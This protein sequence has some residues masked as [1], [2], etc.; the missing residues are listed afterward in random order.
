MAVGS[1]SF[2]NQF[3]VVFT[4]LMWRTVQAVYLD[5]QLSGTIITDNLFENCMTGILLGGGRDNLVMF[6]HFTGNDLAVHLDNRGMNWQQSVRSTRLT[7][8]RACASHARVCATC[9][10]VA[11][12]QQQHR[13]TGS[14]AFFRQLHPTSVRHVIPSVF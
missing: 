2:Q 14:A 10:S 3:W 9:N 1:G 11:E 13:G 5:D 4:L 8:L 12:L 6:N 7:L